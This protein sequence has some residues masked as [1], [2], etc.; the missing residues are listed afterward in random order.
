MEPSLNVSRATQ[1]ERLGA[2][3]TMASSTN[4]VHVF[5]GQQ[6]NVIIDDAASSRHMQAT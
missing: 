6:R 1:R 4:A 3:A 2:S 5:L